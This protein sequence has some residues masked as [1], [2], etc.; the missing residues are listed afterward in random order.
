[1]P[2]AVVRGRGRRVAPTVVLALRLRAA[3]VSCDRVSGAASSERHA[4]EQKSSIG[5]HSS[6]ADPATKVPQEYADRVVLGEDV[7]VSP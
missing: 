1:M 5:T 7:H 3:G 2:L 6:A 4:A